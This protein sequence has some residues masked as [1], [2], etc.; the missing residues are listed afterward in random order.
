MNATRLVILLFAAAAAFA[1]NA[2]PPEFE[3]ATIR[4][5]APSAPESANVGV[6]IDG[7][8]VRWESR[9]FRDYI[10]SGYRVKLYQVS[11][12]D[13]ISSDRFDI[14]AR[15][16]AGSTASQIPE[17]LRGLLAERF[18]LKLHHEKKDFPVYVLELAKGGLKMQ[19]TPPDPSAANTDPQTPVNI[20]ASGSREG[21]AVNLGQGSSYTFSNNKFEAKRLTMAALAANL[22]R[23]LDRPIVDMTDLKGSY[24]FTLDVTQE[25]YRAMLVRAAVSA[26]VVLPPQALR[27]LDGA[28]LP[29][30]SDALQ[31][32][33]LR[34]DPRK[35]PLDLLVI[36]EAQK[37]PTEN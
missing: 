17:M 26:G 15:L 10:T 29:S 20:T 7:A 14:A 34:L 9:T 31:K 12:P 32:L 24:D 8:Q 6:R 2:P 13:W 28:T 1:Q 35:V 33:G 23:F 11:G 30:L 22:E 25:D 3:V 4:P 27:L 5:S 36:D 16:P 19:E 21:V 18:K 37:T